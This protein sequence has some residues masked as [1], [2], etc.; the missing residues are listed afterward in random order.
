MGFTN[1]AWESRS[2][3]Q[4]ARDL[5]GGP[6]LASVGEAGAAWVRIANEWA[7]I[8]EE[9]DNIVDKIGGSFTSQGADAVARKLEELRLWL[10]SISVSAATN[11][12]HAE[13]AA[14]AYSVAV[15]AMPSVS[16]AV[17]AQTA[18]DM[19]ASLAAYNGAILTGQFAE[20]D[21]AVSSHQAAAS[22]VMY[23]YEQAC[24][25]LAAPWPQPGPPDACN[26]AALN[27]E[28]D[29]KAAADRS[30][31]AAAGGGTGE[32]LAPA[33]LAPPRI[34]EVK[35]SDK[36]K[37]SHQSL[38][39]VTG[40]G[41]GGMGGGYG[42]MAALARGATTREH[43]SSLAGSIEGGGEPGA[44]LSP[45]DPSWLPAAAQ[46][47]APFMVSEVSWGPNSAVFDELSAPGEPDA[48]Q[49]AD[50]PQSTLQQVSNRWVAPPVIGG[51]KGLIL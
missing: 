41:V 27:A 16:D 49:Y 2:A 20:F 24:S 28:H 51:D 50:V 19:M 3:A 43:H 32:G 4:L 37:P 29:A 39:A 26:G 31:T 45:A 33:P 42:P 22:A 8:A 38:S 14:V 23:E 10:Q 11:G 35:S 9:Y 17:E 25:D 15:L 5:T 48:P 47:D 40:S 44:G 6:G 34:V 18:H 46:S 30:A 21:E 1:V 7:S 36:S 12:Q 13:E